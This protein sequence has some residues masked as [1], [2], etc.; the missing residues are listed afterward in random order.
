MCACAQAGWLA[1]QWSAL[2]PGVARRLGV[3]SRAVSPC[4]VDALWTLC[5]F[6]A[7]LLGERR[8]GCAALSAQDRRVLEWLDDVGLLEAQGWGAEINYRIAAPLLRDLRLTLQVRAAEQCAALAP[9]NTPGI[10]TPQFVRPKRE[11]AV[12]TVHFAAAWRRG[13]AGG[14]G[15]SGA[16]GRR[17]TWRA[18]P[19]PWLGGGRQQ[20]A[21]RAAALR[22]LRDVGA[23]GHLAGPV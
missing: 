2:A 11:G 16:P 10:P 19:G 8:R 1:E 12:S 23:A 3:A 9:V 18:A 13:C 17:G 22:T 21:A 5:Q 15:A 6:E 4:E 7:G 20:S 14:G